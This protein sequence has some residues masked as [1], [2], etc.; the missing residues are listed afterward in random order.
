MVSSLREPRLSESVED[1]QKQVRQLQA[2]RGR[3]ALRVVRAE[4]LR[5]EHADLRRVVCDQ[6]LELHRLQKVLLDCERSKGDYA[7]RAFAAEKRVKELE[8]K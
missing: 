1:L 6:R 2:A 5:K 4:T 8:G 3:D 7:M